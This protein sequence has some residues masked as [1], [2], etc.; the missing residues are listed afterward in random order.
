MVCGKHSARG[1]RVCLETRAAELAD[2]EH[3]RSWKMEDLDAKLLGDFS[4]RS[5][6]TIQEIR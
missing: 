1:S 4:S 3:H 2:R 6:S 5:T